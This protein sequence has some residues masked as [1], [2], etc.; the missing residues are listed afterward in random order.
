MT[1]DKVIILSILAIFLTAKPALAENESA[2]PN[3]EITGEEARQVYETLDIPV[4][5][6][7]TFPHGGG[8]AIKK[9]GGLECYVEMD[10]DLKTPI[11][12]KCKLA[13][14]IQS[15]THQKKLR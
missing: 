12:W 3:N 5:D 8:L 9:V 10:P 14:K 6:H 13:S 15:E 11:A 2:C 4:S 7:F 1:L